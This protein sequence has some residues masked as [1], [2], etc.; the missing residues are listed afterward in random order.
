MANP[1]RNDPCS[2]GSG[3]RYKEC[4]GRI[5]PQSRKVD[6]V[7][8]GAQKGGTSA[9]DTYLRE[10]PAICMPRTVK[11]VHYFDIDAKFADGV[12]PDHTFYHGFFAP[13]SSHRL[14]G[15]ATPVYMYWKPFA[16]RVHAYNPAM[17]I[18]MLLR[19]PATRAHS[20]W[21]MEVRKLREKL[22]FEEA[23]R[24]EPARLAA[25]PHGQH[26]RVSYIDRGRYSEQLTRIWQLIPRE[27]TLVLRS[28]LLQNDPGQALDRIAQFLGVSPF[29]QAIRRTVNDFPYEAPMSPAAARHLQQVFAPE[30]DALEALT[31]WNLDDW[32]AAVTT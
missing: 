27:Q 4:H 20:H 6:F 5:E 3:R 28:D 32:R 9:L 22:S 23:L 14:I 7:V 17:K 8:A 11:E 13:G 26:K 29:A 12:P 15:E 31:G 19:N 10:H 18:I 25:T 2:C 24:E 1:G 16:A 21:N 30:I